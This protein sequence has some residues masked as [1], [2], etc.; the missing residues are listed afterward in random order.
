MPL[1]LTLT[2]IDFLATLYPSVVKPDEAAWMIGPPGAEVCIIAV[3]GYT[4]NEVQDAASWC[5]AQM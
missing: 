4:E 2:L 1:I 5:I 3:G